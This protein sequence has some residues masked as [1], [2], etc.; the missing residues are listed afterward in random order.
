MAEKMTRD[1]D[2]KIIEQRFSSMTPAMQ[3]VLY[4]GEVYS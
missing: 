4:I 1:N 3:I 2:S